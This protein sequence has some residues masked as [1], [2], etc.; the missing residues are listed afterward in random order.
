LSVNTSDLAKSLT[1][2]FDC[3]RIVYW[4]TDGPQ[5]IFGE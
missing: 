4:K 2:R 1:S 5:R 3:G